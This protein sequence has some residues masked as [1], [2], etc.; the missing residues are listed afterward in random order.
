MRLF[1]A[2]C[3]PDAGESP[4]RGTSSQAL[5]ALLVQHAGLVVAGLID[6][7]A[8]TQVR[9]GCTCARTCT[10]MRSRCCLLA[11]ALLRCNLGTPLR[12]RRTWACW[13]RCSR[14]RWP[15]APARQ[16]FCRSCSAKSE[17]HRQQQPAGRLW[18]CSLKHAVATL[19]LLRSNLAAAAAFTRAAS[20]GMQSLACTHA[21]TSPSSL[22]H[23]RQPDLIRY[24]CTRPPAH[25]RRLLQLLLGVAG[26]CEGVPECR[27]PADLA[28]AATLA[29]ALQ[30][31]QELCVLHPP[32]A[33]LLVAALHA[34][35]QLAALLT[36]Q[37]G[38]G[39]EA[40]VVPLLQ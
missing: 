2:P 29:A 1:G 35:T 12:D 10:H 17:R 19:C 16:T 23:A 24:P 36:A 13:W 26:G 38:C 11:A 31:L 27:A 15:C 40:V 8:A 4:P 20:Q 9:P 30:L 33:A 37:L 28:A 32:A 22:S 18:G 7:L 14:R 5:S 21:C 39:V 6:A 34:S 3:G 25:A